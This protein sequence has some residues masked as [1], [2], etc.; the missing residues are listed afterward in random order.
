VSGAAKHPAI[1]AVE[2]PADDYE[3]ALDLL[4]AF[5][6]NFYGIDDHNDYLHEVRLAAAPASIVPPS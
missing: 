6:E 4:D 3:K 5:C 2:Q 1:Q